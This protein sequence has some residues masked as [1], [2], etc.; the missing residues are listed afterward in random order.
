M[1]RPD[2]RFNFAGRGDIVPELLAAVEGRSR[3]I[4]DRD[5]MQ[6]RTIG[7]GSEVVLVRFRV[8]GLPFDGT[9]PA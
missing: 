9:R 8:G 2:R 5:L 4:I 6:S 1:L 7:G 3:V